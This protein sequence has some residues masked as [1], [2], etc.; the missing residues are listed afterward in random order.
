L[1]REPASIDEAAAAVHR[2]RRLV[3][4]IDHIGGK[5][6]VMHFSRAAELRLVQDGVP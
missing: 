3:A 1:Y 6:P 2:E 5:P 4:E